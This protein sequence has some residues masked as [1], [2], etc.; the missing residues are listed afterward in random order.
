MERKRQKIDPPDYD[1]VSTCS[2]DSH[3][4][5]LWGS[6]DS[7]THSVYNN[8]P[9]LRRASSLLLLPSEIR[10]LIYQYAFSSSSRWDELIRITVDRNFPSHRPQTLFKPMAPEVKLK[11]T[12]SPPLHLPVALL[13]TCHQIYREALPVLLSGI[14]FS[15][16]TN[17][18]SLMFL[19][20][21][22]SATACN[23]VRYLRLYPAPLYVSNGA[24]GEQLSWAVL[25]A[26][27]ARLP[28]LKRMSIVYTRA[29]DLVEKNVELQRSRYGKP[30]SRISAQME[31]EFE[32]PEPAGAELENCHDLFMKIVG[33]TLIRTEA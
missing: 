1:T 24:T 3:T 29:E 7:E 31:P 25:C 28:S 20:D 16:A 5:S 4:L 10:F 9:L 32:G 12:R 27:V 8:P 23:S 2:T 21:R 33:P 11:Y 22:F 17:P 30:L 19:L 6:E 26:R 18:T 14:S 13:R 15:F